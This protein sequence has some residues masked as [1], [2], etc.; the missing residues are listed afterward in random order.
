VGSSAL[1]SCPN[2]HV[3]VH[4]WLGS[5]PRGSRLL[6]LCICFSRPSHNGRLL[7]AG[8]FGFPCRHV[9]ELPLRVLISCRHLLLPRPLGH[10]AEE[11]LGLL[12]A[13]LHLSGSS[14]SLSFCRYVSPSYPDIVLKPAASIH[15]LQASLP[16]SGLVISQVP[17]RLTPACSCTPILLPQEC[18]EGRPFYSCL[19]SQ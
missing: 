18:C 2:S 19:R 4:Q 7:Q 16:W 10:R 5:S 15:G 17:Q 13:H 3:D 14:A 6:L 1:C 9:K 12:L 8:L 11:R